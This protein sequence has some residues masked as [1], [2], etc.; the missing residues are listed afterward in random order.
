MNQGQQE[1]FFI[2]FDTRG[3]DGEVVH[4]ISLD[5]FIKTTQSLEK[6]LDD[7]NAKLFDRKL[8]VKILISPPE[9]GGVLQKFIISIFALAGAI[10]SCSQFLDT[11]NGK[12]FAQNFKI[13]EGEIGDKAG[14]WMVN[15]TKGFLETDNEKIQNKTTLQKQF[16][17]A[18]AGR[19]D[20]YKV[21]INDT[22]IEG[23]EFCKAYK[24]I[25]RNKFPHYISSSIKEK[26]DSEFKIHKLKIISAVIS[27]I[28]TQAKSPKWKGEDY[29][30]NK[31]LEF[32]LMDSE[33]NTKF[34]N[35]H[36]PIQEVN[37]IIAKFEYQKFKINGEINP[38]KTRVSA[39]KIYSFNDKL[40]T[41]S[42][43]LE[44]IS[45]G[46]NGITEKEEEPN[47]FD[48]LENNNTK[49]HDQK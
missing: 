44:I 12:K 18:F 4:Q 47:L 39:V 8:D 23:V 34:L 46:E 33:F 1:K 42:D 48:F 9:N 10:N 24:F 19:S 20:F 22:R 35:D 15:I 38:N 27:K 13:E 41:N 37:V 49:T 30:S 26:L 29:R 28:D 14:K 43:D 16:P 6:I 11:T 32:Y 17:G 21:C 31:S 7:F 2:H 40:I 25:Q 36:Y 3:R 45:I 5:T